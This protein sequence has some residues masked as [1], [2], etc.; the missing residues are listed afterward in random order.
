VVPSKMAG[1]LAAGLEAKFKLST[2]ICGP[3]ALTGV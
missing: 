1:V 2:K 3:W